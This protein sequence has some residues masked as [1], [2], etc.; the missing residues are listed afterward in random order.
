MIITVVVE[1]GFVQSVDGVPEGLSVRVN[2][3]DDGLVDV[4]PGVE[5]NWWLDT[6]HDILDI[7]EQPDVAPEDKLREI[8]D[9]VQEA[10]SLDG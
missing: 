5:T 6:L 2:D 9:T 8:M 10:L 7:G 1:N 4:W 3:L